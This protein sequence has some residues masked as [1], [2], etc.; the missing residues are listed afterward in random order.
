MYMN[1]KEL[2]EKIENCKSKQHALM[3]ASYIV[4]NPKQLIHL[5]VLMND[6]SDTR[7]WRAAWVLDHVCQ[8]NK[9]LIVP[10]VDKLIALFVKSKSESILRVVGKLLS[11]YPVTNIFDGDFVNACFQLIISP[12]VAV[13]VKVHAMQLLFNVS[14]KYPALKPEVK[15]VIEGQIPNNSPA[16]KSRAI[17]LLKKL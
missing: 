11:Q 16:F 6:V 2:T 14:E 8:E 15:I 12:Q 10:Y 17:K 13:A 9:A 1:N 4:D 7:H 5:L 3:L